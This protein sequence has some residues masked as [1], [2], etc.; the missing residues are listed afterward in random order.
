MM[1]KARRYSDTKKIVWKAKFDSV[2]S[3]ILVPTVYIKEL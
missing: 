2:I 1:L 3:L